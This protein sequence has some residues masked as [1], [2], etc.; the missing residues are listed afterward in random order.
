MD[1]LSDLKK[2]QTTLNE[3]I[4]KLEGVEVP[5]EKKGKASKKTAETAETE[6]AKPEKVK[7]NLPMMTKPITEQLKSVL[8]D[9]GVGMTDELK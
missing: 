3:V 2:I 5:K 1:Y 8:D 7:K 4:N 6:D 9:V